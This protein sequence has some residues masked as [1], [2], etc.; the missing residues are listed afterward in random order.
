METWNYMYNVSLIWIIDVNCIDFKHSSQ[1]VPE[2]KNAIHSQLTDVA[3]SS[4]KQNTP[5]VHAFI[6]CSL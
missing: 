5:V 3:L 1:Y 4:L 2:K 6:D